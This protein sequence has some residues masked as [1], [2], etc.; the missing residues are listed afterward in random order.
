MVSFLINFV[1]FVFTFKCPENQYP[2]SCA[3]CLRIEDTESD[4]NSALEICRSSGGDL[5]PVENDAHFSA[6][7]WYLSVLNDDRRLRIGYKFNNSGV[8]VDTEGITAPDV[9]LA[10]DN[11]VGGGGVIG[12]EDTCIGIQ[13]EKFFT[14]PCSDSLVFLCSYNYQG[15][16]CFIR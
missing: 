7:K 13:G 6:L 9:V 16:V 3:T 2:Y 11:Y 12:D 1:G 15:T 8:L 10:G 4:F 5:L 14:S